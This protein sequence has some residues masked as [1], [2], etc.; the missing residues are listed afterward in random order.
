MLVGKSSNVRKAKRVNAEIAICNDVVIITLVKGEGDT[1]RQFVDAL[2]R[3]SLVSDAVISG[4]SNDK[5]KPIFCFVLNTGSGS[6]S[7]TFEVRNSAE[8]GVWLSHLRNKTT[9]IK[10]SKMRGPRLVPLAHL[11]RD[12][13]VR[14][15]DLPDP[16]SLEGQA[17]LEKEWSLIPKV[18]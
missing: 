12:E 16:F 3:E 4:P 15:L 9:A 7:Y 5:E 18:G 13:V 1:T 2:S 6:L 10:P 17:E 8:R 14:W 11:T